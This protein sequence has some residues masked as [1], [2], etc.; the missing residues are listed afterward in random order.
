ME[1]SC[2]LRFGPAVRENRIAPAP[3]F[4]HYPPVLACVLSVG[5][6]GVEAFP[7]EVE[8]NSGWGDTIVVII[9]S[10]SPI[11]ELGKN[12]VTPLNVRPVSIWQSEIKY[13]NTIH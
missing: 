8:V 9:M 1:A 12:M 6:N 3:R 10:I 7:V 4:A 13:D 11:S 2:R 5:L